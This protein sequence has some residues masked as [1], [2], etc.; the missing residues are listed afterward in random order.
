MDSE[1][2]IASATVAQVILTGV[3]AAILQR[4]TNK[5]ARVDFDRGVHETWIDVDELALAHDATLTTADSLLAPKP[6]HD[7]CEFARK[8]WFIL[9]YLNP[10]A[11]VYQGANDGIYGS[12][13][14]EMLAAIRSQLETL[15]VDD[16]A[17]WVSQHHG[18]EK[19]FQD[20]C[21]RIRERINASPAHAGT[22]VG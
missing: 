13:K 18:H 21:T 12:R 3:L 11:T 10:I 5:I 14:K 9:A 1:A 17:Y 2:V 6:V 19:S 16:D 22:P 4:S 8:R 15:L 7:P 20:F